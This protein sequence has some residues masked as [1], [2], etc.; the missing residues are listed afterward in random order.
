[1]RTGSYALAGSSQATPA[2]DVAAAFLEAPCV[3][4][5]VFVVFVPITVALLVLTALGANGTFDKT[6]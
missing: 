2:L 3:T 6:A 1:M 5:V 4:R